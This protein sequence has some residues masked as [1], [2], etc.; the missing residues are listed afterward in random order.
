MVRLSRSLFRDLSRAGR[1]CV[2]DA[3]GFPWR[4]TLGCRRPGRTE[5][6]CDF[7]GSLL[8]D[9]HDD[10]PTVVRHHPELG[11]ATPVY[12]DAAGGAAGLR[13]RTF[14]YGRSEEL[15]VQQALGLVAAGFG[16]HDDF[17]S[18]RKRVG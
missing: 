4:P 11:S 5:A 17:G 2:V 12:P 9:G 16:D 7:F 6:P 18:I 10:N 14:G 3:V 13:R 15:V 8:V 1:R